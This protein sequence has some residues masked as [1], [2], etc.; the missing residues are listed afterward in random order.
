MS[1]AEKLIC[2]WDESV[3]QWTQED[4]VFARINSYFAAGEGDGGDQGYY[5]AYVQIF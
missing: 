3:K 2:V 1:L 4:L 5:T